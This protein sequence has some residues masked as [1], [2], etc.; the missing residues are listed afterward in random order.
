MD[1]APAILLMD[2]RVT[3]MDGAYRTS[4][5]RICKFGLS[6]LG[7]WIYM[8]PLPVAWNIRLSAAVI[9]T[10]SILIKFKNLWKDLD[11]CHVEKL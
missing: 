3:P 8:S 2:T 9:G 1:P 4:F 10:G 5:K 6:L 7:T 11:M